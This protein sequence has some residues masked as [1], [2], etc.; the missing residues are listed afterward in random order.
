[1]GYDVNDCIGNTKESGIYI[2]MSLASWS[3]V[4][5]NFRIKSLMTEPG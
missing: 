3:L 2:Y 4:W 5:S 1:M